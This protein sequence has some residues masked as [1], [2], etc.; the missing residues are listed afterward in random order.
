MGDYPRTYNTDSTA[1][2]LE[3][4]AGLVE[5]WTYLQRRGSITL[6]IDGRGIKRVDLNYVVDFSRQ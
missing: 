4:V 3:M 5:E 1:V 2:S 6:H